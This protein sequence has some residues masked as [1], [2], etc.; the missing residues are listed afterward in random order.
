MNTQMSPEWYDLM[1]EC[2]DSTLTRVQVLVVLND[3]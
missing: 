2:F 1:E 3:L